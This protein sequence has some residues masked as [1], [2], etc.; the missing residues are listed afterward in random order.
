LETHKLERRGG[1][2]GIICALIGLCDPLQYLQ[3]ELD[4]GFENDKHHNLSNKF[5]VTKKLEELETHKCDAGS[6]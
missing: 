6:N 1:T 4:F 3:V 2:Y 5:I